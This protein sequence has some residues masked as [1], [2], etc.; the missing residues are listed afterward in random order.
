MSDRPNF[1]LLI[2]EDAGRYAGCYGDPV[3]R[4][5]NLDRLAA[6]GCRYDNGFSTAPVC[7]PSRST[8]VSG[9]HAWSIGSHHMRST[10]TQP[11]RLFTHEL[12]D[13]GYY[14]SWPTKLDFNFE[15]DADFREDADDWIDKLRHGELS[16]RPFFLYRNFG[17]THEST[18]WAEPQSFGG[19]RDEREKHLHTIAEAH[20]CDPS[21]VRVPAYLPDTPE[22]RADIARFYDALTLMDGQVG[23]VLDALEASPYRDNTVVI[24]LTDHG[25][26]LIRE[27]RWCYDAG[28]HLSLLIRWPNGI[29]AGSVSDELVSWVDVGPTILSLAGV[30]VPGDYQGQVFL[31]P[32]RAGERACV[33]FGRDRMDEAFDRTRGARDRRWHYIRNDFPQ[34][35]WMQRN[36][37]ME[38]QLTTQVA[39][40]M[41]ARGELADSAAQFFADRK[42]PEELY[43]AQADPDMVRNLIDEPACAEHAQRLRAALVENIERF[44]DM[45]EFS[46]RQ[47]IE[48]GV[49][50]NR[51]DDEYRSR[52]GPLAEH[53]RIGPYPQPVLE[54]EE[55][56]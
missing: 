23:Q 15:P 22:V 37:Y 32:A 25:R 36:R 12:R 33:F 3:A 27:K 6:E 17:I 50:V 44:G 19:A 52:I 49:V 5:P 31:G 26:G 14:V 30:D 4:T 54:R 48:R 42:P 20:R 56:E 9:K 28:V 8:L 53:L 40:E 16:D 21:T 13:A 18:M 51:L 35:P 1:I 2:G 34:L 7:A 45:G 24:Y 41:N 11:P 29:E 39:R 38:I 10:L 55:L 47:L 46:E 43:D